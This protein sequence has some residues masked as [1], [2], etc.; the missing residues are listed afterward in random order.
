MTQTT[1]PTYGYAA[2][3]EALIKH[4]HRIEKQVRGIKK[5]LS[6]DRYYIDII[7]QISAVNTALEAVAFK[8]PRRA[9]QSTASPAPSRR[10]TSR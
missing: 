5:M 6:E 7:T 4:P 3:K 1:T 10:V 9:R 2:D 8:I